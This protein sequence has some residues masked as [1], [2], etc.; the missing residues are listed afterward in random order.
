MSRIQEDGYASNV[1]VIHTLSI[2]LTF[3]SV[4]EE[5]LVEVVMVVKVAVV[6]EIAIILIKVAMVEE[7]AT[8]LM[9]IVMVMQTIILLPLQI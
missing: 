7:I 4:T 3:I 9:M 8:T 1:E 2:A 6:V 5:A